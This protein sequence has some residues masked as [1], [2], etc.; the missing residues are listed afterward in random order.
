MLGEHLAHALALLAVGEHRDGVLHVPVVDQLALD[1]E[2]VVLGVV[3]QDQLAR[4]DARDLAAQLG[5]DR[6]A[7]AGDEHRAPGQ[8]AAGELGL[9]PHRLAAEDVLHPHLAHLPH[10]AA[11]VLQQLEHGR[12]RAH[13][14]AAL[15]A[16]AHDARAHRAGSRRD[17][18]QHLVGRDVVEHAPQ[19]LRAAQHLQPAVDPRV[20]LA[21]VVVDEAD[22]AEAEV[23]VAQDLAQQQPAAV[24]GAH[25]QHRAGVAR[26]PPAA[27]R[28]L[29][30][31]VRG[32]AH[33][34]HEDEQ[35]QAEE[36][37]HAGRH[38]QRHVALGREDL[39]RLERGDVGHERDHARRDGLADQQVLAL[40]RVPHPV[41]VEAEQRE[42]ED[43]AADRERDRARE[44][45]LVAGRDPAV[46]P[47]AVGEEIGQRDQ[48][49]VQRDLRERVAVDGKGRGA[50]P[51]AHRGDSR[52]A[53]Q[54]RCGDHQQATA[55]GR[56]A[57]R[58]RGAGGAP[59]RATAWRARRPPRASRRR[60]RPSAIS[61]SSTAPGRPSNVVQTGVPSAT[62]S[63]FMVPP[64]EITRSAKAISDCASIAVSGTM[65]PSSSVR[66]SGVRG[67]TTVCVPRRRSSTAANSGFSNRW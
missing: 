57:R 8:I 28:P 9:H 40:R 38:G 41:P 6:A 63:R 32:V 20:L 17:R 27:Q 58:G 61:A 55:A 10:Q 23:G 62:A 39:L 30:G 31:Q 15:A 34:A 53:R 66:C 26:C 16:R 44:Q 35:E 18:D 65:K 60:S 7:G 4:A 22:R 43:A 37:E 11:A 5:A 54:R 14:H 29:V 52:A 51:A 33:G 45:V 48:A 50:D 67:S 36:H 47:Q 1:L 2:Q 24:A 12:H 49:R 42:D 59:G 46:E 13:G 64:A 21:R 56:R 3:E 25:D 19:L